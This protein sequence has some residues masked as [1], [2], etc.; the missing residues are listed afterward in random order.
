MFAADCGFYFLQALNPQTL[1]EILPETLEKS[2][3][4]VFK[5]GCIRNVKILA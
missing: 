3:S 1:T 5:K 4:E 2:L